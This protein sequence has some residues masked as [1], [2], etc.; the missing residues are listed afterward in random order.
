MVNATIFPRLNRCLPH[1]ILTLSL[2]LK[3]MILTLYENCSQAKQVEV[4]NPSRRHRKQQRDYDRLR[5][6]E[7][8]IVERLIN[9]LKW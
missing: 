2:P 4:V 8:N 6:R 3:N 9:R 1:S 5:Y 7:R